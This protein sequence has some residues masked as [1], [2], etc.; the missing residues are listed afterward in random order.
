M[1]IFDKYATEYDSWFIEN[2]LLYDAEVTAISKLL[3][4]DKDYIEV[5]VGTGLFATKLGIKAGVEPSKPM[6]EIAIKRGIKVVDGV[7]EHLPLENDS[8]Q[9]ILMVTV[10]CFIKDILPVFTE[11]FRVLQNGGSYIIAFIDRETPL[12]EGYEKNKEDSIYY[13]GATFRSS[14]EMKELL[15]KAGFTIIE[16]MQTV[17]TLNNEIQPIN[18]GNG[19]GVF[20]VVKAKKEI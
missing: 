14:N 20:A 6:A 16:S 19:E 9:G 11:A 2:D 5:G 18:C 17:Y 10:D 4:K 13:K 8:T 12:G 15:S 7:A 3:D 1:S